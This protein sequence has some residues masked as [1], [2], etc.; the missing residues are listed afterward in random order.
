MLV[1][2]V[3]R[4]PEPARLWRDVLAADPLLL[5]AALLANGLAILLKVQRWQIMLRAR[6]HRYASKDAWLAFCASLY[7]GMVTPGR[8]GDALRVQYLRHD[9]GVRYAEGIASVVMDRLC[10]LHV[11]AALV[12]LALFG[13]GHAL[14]ASLASLSWAVVAVTLLCPLVLLVPGV[15]ERLFSRVYRRFAGTGDDGLSHFLGA[16]RAQ[17]G[18]PLLQTVPLTVVCFLVTFVQ[19]FLVARALHIPLSYVDVMYLL[20]VASL[21]GLLP[22]SVSG[23]GVRELFFSLVFPSLGHTQAEAVSYGLLVFFV[24]YVAS[25]VVGAVAWQV[26]PPPTAARADP[27]LT[28]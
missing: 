27:R 8:V 24:V 6:G 5:S 28:R 22:V 9:L 21:L 25:A 11:L 15:S 4:L 10:D 19:G 17:L 14:G 16:L 1:L 13:Y 18:R 7:L 26:R 2:L 20:S 3:V 12:T 23:L